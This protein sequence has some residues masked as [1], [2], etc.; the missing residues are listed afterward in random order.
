M[1]YKTPAGSC[2]RGCGGFDPCKQSV[3]INIRPRVPQLIGDS[4]GTTRRLYYL[5]SPPAQRPSPGAVLSPAGYPGTSLGTGTRSSLR[6]V[7]WAPRPHAWSTQAVTPE[8]DRSARIPDW[9]PSPVPCR[10]RG[11]DP[12]LL[13]AAGARARRVPAHR[14]APFIGRTTPDWVKRFPSASPT[15]ALRPPN[16]PPAAE[17]P[18]PAAST[19]LPWLRCARS[20]RSSSPRRLSRSRGSCSVAPRQGSLGSSPRQTGSRMWPAIDGF[21]SKHRFPWGSA[22]LA[23]PQAW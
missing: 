7:R 18:V 5:P 3:N 19:A 21:L 10:G 6:P 4:L 15:G 14:N 16:T 2:R 20:Y 1:L 13:R 9:G 23:I 12:S 11:R 17:C 22:F 8:W